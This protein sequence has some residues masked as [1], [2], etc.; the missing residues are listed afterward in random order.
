MKILFLT[1]KD[2]AHPF[3]WWAEQVMYE[4]AKW[5]VKRWHQVTRFWYAFQDCKTE[6]MIDG[7]QIIRKF[8]LSTSFFCFPRYYKEH[9]AWKY[10]VIV[11]EAGWLPLL[12]PRY[13]KHIPILFFIHHVAD[14]ELSYRFRFPFSF[15]AK[16]FYRRVLKQYRNTP[17][18]TVSSSTREEM[19][20]D[21]GFDEKKT[22]VIESA[23]DLKAIETIDWDTKQ[24][25]VTFLGRLMPIKRVEDAIR[26]FSLLVKKL[27]KYTM[28][29]I[30]NEQNKAYVCGVKALVQQLW[31]TDAVQ[32]LW[33]ISRAELEK[34][35]S[36][37]KLLLVPSQKEG[38]GLV[39]IEGNCYGLPA[40]GYAVPGLKESIHDWINGF[41]LP[42]GN[43]QAMG[44]KM[45]TLLGDENILKPL[46]ESTLTYAQS[47]PSWDAKV[48]AFESYLKGL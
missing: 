40:L 12:S 48:D 10:D 45:I 29:I 24:N 25:T 1:W 4:Y 6:E 27:P 5:L 38:F 16:H 32:F 35:L 41:L 37:S 39:V 14:Q 22:H 30:G 2:I 8:S 33:Y 26:A 19:I 42:D 13:E 34:R 21:F 43:R 20:K 9:F 31:L 47:L 36:K 23:C 44:E 18:I 17:T 28:Q 3:A 46:S 15:L 7:I 11:D